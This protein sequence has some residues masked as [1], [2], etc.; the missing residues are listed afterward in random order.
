MKETHLNTIH[1][2]CLF[3][4]TILAFVSI[5]LQVTVRNDLS[6]DSAY[7]INYPS[8][9]DYIGD[10][11]SVPASF[12]FGTSNALLASAAVTIGVVLVGILYRISIYYEV[13]ATL[14]AS[15]TEN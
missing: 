5:G 6:I 10:L 11:A 13:S 4:T 12:D 14:D 1:I 2:A 3:V 15:W 8:G 7:G 9:R